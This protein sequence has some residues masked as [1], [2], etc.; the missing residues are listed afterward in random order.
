MN[1]IVSIIIPNYNKGNYVQHSLNSLLRQTCHE[2]EAIVVDDCSRDES[3]DLI[4]NYA[5]KD[6]RIRAFRNETNKGGNYSRNFGARKAHG[7]YLIFLDSDD[8][9]A[10]D[11]IENRV[12][13][14]EKGENKDADL[15]VFNMM[16]TKDGKNGSIWRY[17]DRRKPLVSFL[18]H[19]IPWS[20]MMPVWRRPAF[21]RIGGF[22]EAFSRLQDVELHTRTLL[23]G[24]KFR[25][26]QRKSPD[27]FYN[28]EEA[29]MTTNHVRAAENF[30][31]A[32]GM[33]VQKMRGLIQETN[34][35]DKEKTILINALQETIMAAISGIGN[36]YQRGLVKKDERDGLYREIL[37]FGN[38]RLPVK[39]YAFFYKMRLNKIKGVNF[40][41]RKVF[42]FLCA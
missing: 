36:M 11:C 34:K 35:S 16:S 38:G 21:E 18:R 26:A 15:L 24:L 6:A 39:W 10:D 4:Q 33:Y 25:F 42:R 23:N 3:W 20:I 29:R 14:F 32:C 5:A 17:G 2:W 27:C 40:A 31:K 37:E 41:C 12:Q 30:A 1:S 28:I 13:E 8:W 22:D 7:E 9:L 19:E